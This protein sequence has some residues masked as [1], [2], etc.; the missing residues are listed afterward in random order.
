M[1]Y[2]SFVMFAVELC[3]ACGPARP[4]YNVT[5]Y[6]ITAIVGAFHV[7]TCPEPEG[8][9]LSTAVAV[10]I[11]GAPGTVVGLADFIIDA[12][13]SPSVFFAVMMK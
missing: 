13:L 8:G 11:V 3:I 1:L 6:G 7:S 2:F 5:G 4:V 12:A 9:E 10:P